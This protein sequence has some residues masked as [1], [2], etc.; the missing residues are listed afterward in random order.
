MIQANE[1]RLGNW[2][3]NFVGDD[4]QVTQIPI[5]P[6]FPSPT[7]IP[8]SEE[9]LLR[10]GFEKSYETHDELYYRKE[11]FRNLADYGGQNIVISKTTANHYLECGYY[12]NVIDCCYVHSLQNL[13]FALTGEELT[14]I[15]PLPESMK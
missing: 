9:W 14:L 15:N 7:P 8:I 11:G 3:T 5:S 12:V 4:F 6:M 2:L 10:F 13:Y 1:L